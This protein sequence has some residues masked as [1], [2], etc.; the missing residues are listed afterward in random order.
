MA[1]SGDE[2][3]LREIASV[4]A[5]PRLRGSINRR[6][7]EYK[8]AD[9]PQYNVELRLQSHQQNSRLLALEVRPLQHL[10]AVALRAATA[11]GYS[12]SS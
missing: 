9:Q 8:R 10:G 1:R 11:Y 3:V 12:L 2:D 6:G 4:F 5:I 7:T